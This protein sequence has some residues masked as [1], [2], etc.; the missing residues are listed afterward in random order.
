MMMNMKN[1][2]QSKA[3]LSSRI[4]C[5]EV[6]EH[7]KKSQSSLWTERWDGWVMGELKWNYG[8]QSF[9][10]PFPLKWD[11]ETSSIAA[12]FLPNFLCRERYDVICV[13][14]VLFIISLLGFF[15]LTFSSC[16]HHVLASNH[17]HLYSCK[18][19]CGKHFL[20]LFFFLFHN[21]WPHTEI[22]G[23]EEQGYKIHATASLLQIMN[24]KEYIIKH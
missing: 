16:T 22:H 3:K 13:R 24:N 5:S 6:T 12:D 2:M 20:S 11:D 15:I 7:V 21:H 17:D 8:V 23:K 10:V 4:C 19:W 14:M 18:V 9:L 1:I